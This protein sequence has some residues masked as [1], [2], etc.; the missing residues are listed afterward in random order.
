MRVISFNCEDIDNAAQQ[1]FFQWGAEQDADIICLQ[2]TQKDDLYIEKNRAIEGYLCYAHDGYKREGK[3]GGVAIYTKVQ[4]KAVITGLGFPEADETGRY[5]QI[6]FEN[7][8]IASLFVPQANT[9]D[10]QALKHRFLDGYA[11]NL[12]KQR[13]K[14]REFII[15]GTWNIVSQNKDA[16]E[17]YR[18]GEFGL[19]DSECEWMNSLFKGMNFCDAYREIDQ[20]G[21]HY[22]FWKDEEARKKNEGARFDYQIVTSAMKENVVNG[23]IYTST[24]FS[25][26]APVI[27]DYEWE[28][29]EEIALTN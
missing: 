29:S 12:N 19:T 22:S 9:E 26:H 25:K 14:R 28:L 21:G 5:I 13:R 4:P 1:G 6:D 16:D 11:H 15:C 20:E 8:S 18:Q 27:I 10:E 17:L 24:T 3:A 2:N 7:I 23:G